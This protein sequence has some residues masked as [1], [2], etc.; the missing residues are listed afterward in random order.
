MTTPLARLL[1]YGLHPLLMPTLLCGI[2]FY[3][4]PELITNLVNFNAK[5]SIPFF[6][7]QL[8]FRGGLLLL[9]F[10][11]TYLIPVYVFFVLYKLRFISSLRMET[12]AERRLPYVLTV[13]LYTL[14]TLA[15]FQYLRLLPQ[16]TIL[17]AA[18]TFCIACVALISLRWQISAHATGIGGVVGGLAVLL[19][20]TGISPLFL[21]LVVCLVL[22][23]AVV[24]A[25]LHLNAHTPAQVAAGFGLG[26]LVSG[27][28][29][30]VYF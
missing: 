21:P 8:S 30:G 3:R 28:T 26:L 5:E 25:R 19:L 23:G 17:M 7:L 1:S 14:F 2:L 13:L 12:L 27:I 22:A 20:K 24:S 16:L 15:A 11:F 10:F 6:G 9:V 18:M 4:A 29:L